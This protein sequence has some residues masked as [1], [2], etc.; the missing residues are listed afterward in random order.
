MPFRLIIA[1]AIFNRLMM[2]IFH[3][4]FDDFVLVFFNDILI[5]S[6]NEEDNAHHVRCILKLLR[7]N[8]LYAKRSKCTFFTN[9]IKYLGFIISKEGVSTDPSKVEAVVMWST[10]KS[11]R[12][13]R[14]FLGLIGWYHVF[15][16]GYAKI[17]SPLTNT[18]KK[19]I[20][21]TWTKEC[22]EIFNNL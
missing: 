19:I 22:E 1:L 10:P 20:V 18:L 21:F 6:K 5:Y 3:K 9:C 2:D 17:A 16:I 4:N 7:E 8:N 11:I 12:E 15:I 14:G 13:V